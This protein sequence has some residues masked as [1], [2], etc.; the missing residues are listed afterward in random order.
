MNRPFKLTQSNYHSPAARKRWFSS[1]E[2][3]AAKRCE[4]SWLAERQGKV[5]RQ[6]DKPAFLYGHLFEAA[7]TMPPTQ[8]QA[9]LSEH[10]E[11]LSS[12]GAT[13]GELLS[14]YRGALDLAKAVRR[15]PYLY[16]VIRRSKKQVILTGTLQGMP[17]RVMMDLLDKDTSIYDLKSMRDFSSKYNPVSEEWQDWWAYWDYPMQL[18]IY[19]EIARQNGMSVPHVGLIAGSKSDLDVQALTF[20]DEI[21]NAAAA[22]TEYTLDRMDKILAGSEEPQSCGVCPWCLRHKKITAFTEI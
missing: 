2:V 1:S 14:Q 4:S 11:L 9:W 21:M 15:S 19:Q 6:E 10:P 16:G 17:V 7:L 3:K 8:F 5:K 13:K 18:Y 20:G 12:R 22:D